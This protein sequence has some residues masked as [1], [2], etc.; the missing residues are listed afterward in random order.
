MVAFTIPE[1]SLDYWSGGLLS[2]GLKHQGTST[3]LGEQVLSLHDP[4]GMVI[5]LVAHPRAQ[6]RPGWAI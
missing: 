6:E 4:D 3:S 5:E 2:G 1:T